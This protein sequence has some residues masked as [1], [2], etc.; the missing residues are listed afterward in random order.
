MKSRYDKQGCILHG[1]IWSRAMKTHVS[2]ENLKEW[3]SVY[4]IRWG[5]ILTLCSPSSTFGTSAHSPDFTFGT[6]T[7]T[8]H[9]EL[10]PIVLHLWTQWHCLEL[11]VNMSRIT[12]VICTGE[13]P[14]LSL[15]LIFQLGLVGVLKNNLAFT[16]FS[17]KQG[18]KDWTLDSF[19]KEAIHFVEKKNQ[20]RKKIPDMRLQNSRKIIMG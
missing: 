14:A 12:I 8:T 3:N 2:K 4:K 11:I 13:P 10:N 17:T 19:L 18:V 7:L 1:I 5:G 16:M 9:T 20:Y 6:N 15:L